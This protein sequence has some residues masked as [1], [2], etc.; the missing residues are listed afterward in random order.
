MTVVNLVPS[1][2]MLRFNHSVEMLLAH[3]G[4]IEAL[5]EEAQLVY[6]VREVQMW[7]IAGPVAATS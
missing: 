5:K 2:L 6:Y 1:C 3:P 7:L 4:A